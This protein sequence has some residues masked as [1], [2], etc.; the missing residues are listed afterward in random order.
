MSYFQRAVPVWARGEQEPM[1]SALGI[2]W[3]VPA[4]RGVL[5]IACAGRFR[6]L[7]N[8]SFF[9]HGPE[10]AAHG[11]A[12]VEEWPISEALVMPVNRVS[13]EVVAASIAS[14]YTVKESAF[15]Q[16]EIVWEGETLAHT[17]PD[18]CQATA[19][20]H[21]LRKVH[22]YSFQRTFSEVYRL[23]PGS[24]AWHSGGTAPAPLPVHT[25]NAP[26]LLPRR[27]PLPVFPFYEASA[28][29]HFSF[30][31][32]RNPERWQPR[33]IAG[34]GSV[35]EG[36]AESDLET[37]PLRAWEECS[38][39]IVR[40]QGPTL[41]AGQGATYH[42]TANRTGFIKLQI[43]VAEPA[44]IL[45]S[46]DEIRTALRVDITRADAVNLLAWQLE[47]GAYTLESFEP[48]TLKFLQIFVLRGCLRIASV[49]L[50][51]YEAPIPGPTAVSHPSLTPVVAAAWSTIRQNAA[52]LL[53]D[54]PSR[55]RAGWLW[56]SLYSARVTH[57]LSGSPDFETAFL[58]NYL[59]AP[60]KLEG[61]PAGMLPMCY[62]ADHPDGVFIPQWSL[63]LVLQ[64]REYA[65][66]RRGD[67]N[68]VDGFR[69]KIQRLF[70]WFAKFE[71]SDGLLEDLPGWQ[72]I[73][74]SRANELVKGV[75]FPTNWLYAASL[76]AAADLYDSAEY[77]QKAD[78]IH[79][80]TTH[81]AWNGRWFVD[82]AVRKNGSLQVAA[83]STETCQYYAFY[84]GAANPRDQENLWQILLSEFG[85]APAKASDLPWARANFLPG[86][87]MRF[88][89][90]ARQ[91]QRELLVAE[92]Q[93]F[94]ATM[95]QRTGTLWEHK[96]T[97]ASCCH[98][99]A[100]HILV[101]LQAGGKTGSK[102]AG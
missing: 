65:R 12:R 84:F 17:A 9:A 60:D 70:E 45:I 14:Y 4:C 64:L 25:V 69:L 46:F 100:A 43:E 74:W 31:R 5:R 23:H 54:C 62:P 34:I 85:P 37:M 22:R 48:Y 89:L 81:L 8:G 20:P 50:R 82:H 97:R 102:P 71:N 27:A 93:S 11:F 58:E 49:G 61:L 47:K 33:F 99:F 66:C 16:A 44:E 6:V 15:I 1:N 68:L 94:L 92:A 18:A 101:C 77:Q 57:M 38:K 88:E 36:F 83:D 35:S 41:S 56:D 78:R 29:D 7:V 95:A 79:A 26:E 63:W 76:A 67:Q 55:E 2:F 32:D 73:E 3:D 42:L 75:N 51:G 39:L 13:I 87:H 30:E 24:S 80:T 90:L 21:R 52:D 91:N 19:L 59:L 72:F 53:T 40:P 10:R 96:D 86:F 28:A 98:A